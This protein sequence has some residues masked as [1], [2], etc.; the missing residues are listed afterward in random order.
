MDGGL[1]CKVGKKTG[2]E[3]GRESSGRRALEPWAEDGVGTSTAAED[4]R[5]CA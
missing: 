3:R 5:G 1:I 2:M 4:K